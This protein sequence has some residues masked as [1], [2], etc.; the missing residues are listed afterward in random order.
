MLPP[1]GNSDGTAGHSDEVSASLPV[2]GVG[3]GVPSDGSIYPHLIYLVSDD[4]PQ[5][6]AR[7]CNTS[8][9]TPSYLIKTFPQ[10][11]PGARRAAQ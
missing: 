5:E 8:A 2:A 3:Q 4:D 6:V 10:S 1:A 9:S 7:L 11:E